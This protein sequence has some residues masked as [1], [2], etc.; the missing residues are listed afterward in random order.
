[1]LRINMT[2]GNKNTANYLDNITLFFSGESGGRLKGDVNCD[3]EVSIADVTALVNLVMNGSSNDYS[4]VN[5]DGE[6]SIAD[7]TT[8]VN[9]LMSN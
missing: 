3:G 7:V 2:A 5:E 4:D 9:M 8:L 6:T 1:M